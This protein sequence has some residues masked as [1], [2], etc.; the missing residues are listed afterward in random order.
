MSTCINGLVLVSD[1]ALLARS[2]QLTAGDRCVV[3]VVRSIAEAHRLLAEASETRAVI[4]DGVLLKANVQ[5]EIA[6]FRALAPIASILFVAGQFAPALVNAVQAERAQL[7]ARPL[8][9]S[10]LSLFIDR[11]FAAGR[12]PRRAMSQWVQCFATEYRLSRADV[13]LLPLVLGDEEMERAC[14]RLGLDQPQIARGL[15]R[16]VKKCRVRNTD[17]LARNLMRD[18]YLYSSELTA[19]LIEPAHAASF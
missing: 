11:A 13:A 6:R 16:L 7:V 4:L 10:A 2:V 8:P 3:T 1:D 18:A 9:A 14:E 15:R 19:E 17:R 12:L 5:S